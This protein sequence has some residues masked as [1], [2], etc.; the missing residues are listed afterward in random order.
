MKK[1]I[2]IQ[3]TFMAVHFSGTAQTTRFG[4]TAGAIS[5]NYKLKSDGSSMNEKSKIGMT[6]GLMAD[7]PISKNFSFQTAANFVQKGTKSENSYGGT[8]EKSS[9][10][11]NCIE[12]PLDFLYNVPGNGGNFFVGAGPSFAFCISAKST[13]DDGS[14]PTSESLNI[15]NS[16]D[17]DIRGI[18]MGANFTTGYRFK[19]GFLLSVNYNAG[20][21][22]VVPG[23][24]NGAKVKSSYFGLKLGYLLKGNEK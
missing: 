23:E 14:G 11:V 7:I 24:S 4:F 8:T 15:G 21:S 3:L 18:D 16:D 13:Y 10:T 9:T 5:A 2:F 17:D 22:N 12:V 20:L 1:L 19:N 6:A